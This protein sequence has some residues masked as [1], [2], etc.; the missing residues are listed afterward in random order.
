MASGRMLMTCICD[1]ERLWELRAKFNTDAPVLLYTWLI[2]WLDINGIYHGKAERIKRKVFPVP[3]DAEHSV[4]AIESYIQAMVDMGLIWRYSADDGEQYIWFP[5]FH[6]KQVFSQTYNEHPKFPI[7]QNIKDHNTQ[8]RSKK[9]RRKFEY[10]EPPKETPKVLENILPKT[11]DMISFM[12][13]WEGKHKKMAKKYLVTDD[14][15]KTA[16]QEALKL[17]GLKLI[18]CLNTMYADYDKQFWTPKDFIKFLPELLEMI[19]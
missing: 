10:R 4:E 19:K 9:S 7:T 11:D 2:S 18:K 15:D 5:D 16:I 12:S 13:Y 14:E 3:M 6:E 17:H 1:S 8:V